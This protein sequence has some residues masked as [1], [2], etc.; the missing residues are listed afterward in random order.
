[1]KSEKQTTDKKE[2]VKKDKATSGGGKDKN[3]GGLPAR[4][5][6]AG[7]ADKSGRSGGKGA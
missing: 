4:E 3:D 7:G 5:L 1:M 6:K 2:E